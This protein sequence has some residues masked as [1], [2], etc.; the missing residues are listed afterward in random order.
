MQLEAALAEMGK[1]AY[2]LQ[3][4]LLPSPLPEIPGER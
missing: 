4:R 3:G 2:T 1:T